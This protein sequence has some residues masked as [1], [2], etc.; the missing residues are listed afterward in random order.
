MNKKILQVYNCPKYLNITIF[1]NNGHK[2]PKKKK[3]KKNL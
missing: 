3:K 2:L 1:N